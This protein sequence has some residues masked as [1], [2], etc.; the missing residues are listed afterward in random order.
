MIAEAILP[1]AATGSFCS[2]SGLDFLKMI[3][4]K[5]VWI[6]DNRKELTAAMQT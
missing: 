3:Q 6:N 5:A 1:I 4:R 2:L